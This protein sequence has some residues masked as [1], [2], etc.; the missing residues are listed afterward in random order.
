MASQSQYIAFKGNRRV[1]EGSLRDV[2]PK[3]KRN[4][5]TSENSP[6]LIF[7][8]ETGKTMDFNFQG[9]EQDVLKRLE[10]YQSEAA[11][12]PEK[13]GPG[14]PKIGVISRE[15]SLL[16]RHWEWLAQQSGGA[17]ATLRVLVEQA[18]KKSVQGR[19]PK[20]AMERTHAFLSVLAGDLINFE[21][22]LRALYR[23]EKTT[24]STLMTSWPEDIRQQALE[25]AGPAFSE[26]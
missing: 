12:A 17:S 18:T 26:E 16:P 1:Y 9:S 11:P 5:G 8:L 7:N 10:V 14:R 22:V 23:K 21:E 24:F 15:V 25:F 13:A 2:V 4:L 6:Y 19:G 3:I 20:L